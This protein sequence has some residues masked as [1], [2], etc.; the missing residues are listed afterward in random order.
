MSPSTAPTWCVGPWCWRPRSS[1]PCAPGGRSSRMRRCGP[2]RRPPSP[3]ETRRAAPPLQPGDAR[4]A[5]RRGPPP[6]LWGGRAGAV[7]GTARV[8]GG[9]A[10]LN[11]LYER[12][13]D[14][15]MSRTRLRPLP[16]ARVPPADAQVF[17]V[18]LAACGL[19]LLLVSSNVTAT[20]L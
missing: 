3:P 20:L 18:V 6:P 13:P 5:P 12:D 4:E 10:V 19:A 17:G 7:G 1:C 2:S 11:Q 16:D 8:A 9:S 15:L 14:A